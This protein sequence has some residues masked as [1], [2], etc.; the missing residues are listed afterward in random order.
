MPVED[1]LWMMDDWLGTR[2]HHKFVPP[3]TQATRK[4]KKMRAEGGVE[5][6]VGSRASTSVALDA[7][8]ST[9]AALSPSPPYWL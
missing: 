2:P 8:T 4:P 3:Y 7:G 6:E 1:S 5:V 9:S